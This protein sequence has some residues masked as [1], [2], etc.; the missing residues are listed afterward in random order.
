[1]PNVS[2]DSHQWRILGDFTHIDD[3]STTRDESGSVHL[4]RRRRTSP[5][6]PL[7]MFHDNRQ[8]RIEKLLGEI[9]RAQREENAY[10]RWEVF[11]LA[12]LHELSALRL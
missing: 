4:A 9:F 3:R 10:Q 7:L 2:G 8:Q 1:M 11:T 12:M 6:T 5:D